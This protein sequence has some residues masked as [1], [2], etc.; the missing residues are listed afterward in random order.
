MAVVPLL[1]AFTDLYAHTLTRRPGS[2]PVV[3]WV[4]GLVP[5]VWVWLFVLPALLVLRFPDGRLPSPRWRWM[6]IALTGVALLLTLLSLTGRDTY[7]APYI[8]H[9]PV[10][11]VPPALETLHGVVSVLAVVT[12][13]LL[14]LASAVSV[15]ARR[16]RSGDVL[17]RQQLRWIS[18]VGICLPATLLLCFASYLVWGRPDLVLLGV[19]ATWVLLPSATCVAIVH[20]DLYDVDRLAAAAVTWTALMGIF[21]VLYTGATVA[22]AALLGRGSPLLAAIITLPLA[23]ALVP[24]R[25]RLGRVI[26]RWL[27]PHRARARE[28]V[29]RLVADV[30]AGT[31][32]P[33]AL[34]GSLRTALREKHLRVGYVLPGSSWLTSTTGEPLP[35]L[36]ASK[37]TD[38]EVPVRLGETEV[39]RILGLS[40]RSGLALRDLTGPMALLTEMTRLRI[41]VTAALRET[42][43]SRRRLQSVGYAERR[44][45]ERDLHDGAQAR[46]VSLGMNLRVAQRHL[47][48]DERM[49]ELMDSLIDT[50]VAELGTAVGELRQLAHGIRP[51]CL[52]DGLRAALAPLARTVPVPVTVEVL[53]GEL[54][55]DVSATAYYVVMEAV[56]NAIKHAGAS[57]VEVAVEQRAGTLRVRVSDDGRGGADGAGSGWAG[58]RDRVAAVGGSLA[59][60]SPAG[61]GTAV[62]AVLPCA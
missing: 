22:A 14:L 23:L 43:E 8:D 62:E 7:S 17:V 34:E 18:L 26:D 58:V 52:D 3:A 44:R 50:T 37:A 19:A 4:A 56:A 15:A 12:L 49:H 25:R 36:S 9:S 24:L 55:E 51:S 38:V 40:Q 32:A 28:A 53:A 33:E 59:L 16:R 11:V 41:E 35:D 57:R 60:I 6:P 39:A 13:L 31:A 42:E 2:L 21:L 20:H 47:G 5:M 29:E 54:S 61:A 10:W 27:Y 30:R 45:L 1:I 46:L 48:G